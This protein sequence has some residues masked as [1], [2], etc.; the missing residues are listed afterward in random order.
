MAIDPRTGWLAIAE[1]VQ[2]GQRVLFTRRDRD[3]AEADLRRVLKGMKRRLSGPPKGGVYVS[4]IARG[5][6]LFGTASEE[7][8][9][10]R[11]EIGDVPLAGFF[12]SGEIS[13]GRLY[14]YTGVLTLFC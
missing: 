1:R 11:E 3:S 13:H 7:L 5:P 8:T 14:G 10:V 4:C 2:P 12:A 9:I 6:N